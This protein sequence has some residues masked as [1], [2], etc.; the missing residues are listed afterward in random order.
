MLIGLLLRRFRYSKILCTLFQRKQETQINFILY[1][2]LVI[3]VFRNTDTRQQ[4][5]S[6]SN[7]KYYTVFREVNGSYVY[8]AL[9]QT[10]ICQAHMAYLG[11]SIRYI[12]DWPN[13]KRS[14][15]RNY[16]VFIYK[17]LNKVQLV[18]LDVVI[19]VYI[20]SCSYFLDSL[21]LSTELVAT[22]SE[23]PIGFDNTYNHM[24]NLFYFAVQE[25]AFNTDFTYKNPIVLRNLYIPQQT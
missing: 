3:R 23:I 25:N 6:S 19:Q 18:I 1:T 22:T 12:Y 21:R 14:L 13:L 9:C 20:F 17:Q 7:N 11:Q 4:F 5:E 15:H 16:K 10:S 8:F 2:K 24:L